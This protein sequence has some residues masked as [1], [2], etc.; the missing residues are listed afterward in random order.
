MSVSQK[1]RRAYVSPLRK[2][3]EAAK[4]RLATV[5]AACLHWYVPAKSIDGPCKT[6]G[7]LIAD[8]IHKDTG[9]ASHA[10]R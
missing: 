2:E 9:V 7:L 6:C 5:T 10:L 4:A 3:L 8:A 1:P